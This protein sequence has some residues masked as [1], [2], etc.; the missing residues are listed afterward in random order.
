[1]N[2]VAISFFAA[3]LTA[4]RL[5]A[6]ESSATSVLDG[7]LLCIRAARLPGDLAAQLPV[8]WPTNG[9]SGAILDLRFAG[10]GKNRF[11][12]GAFLTDK[13]LPLILLV[14]GQTRGGA[15]EL[16]AQLRAGG[17][18]VVIGPTNF[19]GLTPDIVVTAS[20]EADKRFQEDPFAP[21]PASG[22]ALAATNDLLPFIDHT[23]EADL[24]SKRV[25]DGDETAAEAP[26]AAPA[27]PVIR[28]PA[29]ARAVDLLKALAV[30]RPARG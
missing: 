15:T 30:L 3:G 7:N 11:S 5:V 24:V 21:S 6:A 29:L 25:K 28:D 27:Q 17:Q 20:S 22:D 2:W 4:A 19:T 8:V 14:N 10:G 23:S 18:C 16:A 9:I 1:M 12:G 13:K 26:R